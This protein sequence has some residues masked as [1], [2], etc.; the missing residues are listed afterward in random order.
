MRWSNCALQL[1]LQFR[2]V[3]RNASGFALYAA[4]ISS[5]LV[6]LLP[7]VANLYLGPPVPAPDRY[8]AEFLAGMRA[9]AFGIRENNLVTASAAKTLEIGKFLA[10]S[11][12]S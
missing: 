10:V 8:E 1:F 11:A 3:P 5:G 4:A 12:E 2:Y 7:L 6:S 9:P